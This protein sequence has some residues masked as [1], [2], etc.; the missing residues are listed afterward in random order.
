MNLGNKVLTIIL[1][2]LLI[3]LIAPIGLSIGMIPVTLQTFILFLIPL[4][5]GKNIGLISGVL[6]LIIGASGIPVFGAYT[7][8]IEKLIGPT[9]GFLLAF[10]LISWYVGWAG[11]KKEPNFFFHMII[12]FRAHLG[13]F[14]SPLAGFTYK[15]H[16][17][18]GSKCLHSKPSS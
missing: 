7:S 18:R 9:A 4:I 5:F 14:C 10:P 13:N 3:C 15:N 16:C 2:Q 17:W 11:E 1:I 12:L 6:Y 8:G